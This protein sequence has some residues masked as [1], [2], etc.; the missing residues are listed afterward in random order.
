ML[1]NRNMSHKLTSYVDKI[2]CSIQKR[3]SYCGLQNS[4]LWCDIKFFSQKISQCSIGYTE[5]YVLSS[6]L[7]KLFISFLFVQTMC[8]L[9][10]QLIDSS[11]L[12]SGFPLQII[13]LHRECHLLCKFFLLIFLEKVFYSG[14]YEM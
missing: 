14:L 5:Y 4:L 6:I 7:S 13:W 12:L 2:W 10:L 9:L 3:Y 1:I 8:N 11:Y